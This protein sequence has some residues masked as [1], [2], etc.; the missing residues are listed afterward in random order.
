MQ[1]FNLSASNV[2]TRHRYCQVPRLLPRA[3]AMMPPIRD[4][5]SAQ[6]FLHIVTFSTSQHQSASLAQ[7][8]ERGTSNAE[9]T[10]STPLG[11]IDLLLSIALCQTYMLLFLFHIMPGEAVLWFCGE[12]AVNEDN[13]GTWAGRTPKPSDQHYS[14]APLLS[15]HHHQELWQYCKAPQEVQTW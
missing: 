5:W 12:K 6:S 7:L 1:V 2:R 9:V 14:F 4:T 8:V 11:G 15:S 10:G 13:A 3:E